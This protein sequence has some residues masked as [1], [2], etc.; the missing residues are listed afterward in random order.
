MTNAFQADDKYWSNAKNKWPASVWMRFDRPHLLEKIGFRNKEIY[1]TP[2]TV[3]VI[4]SNDCKSWKTLLSVEDSG[5]TKGNE[6]RSWTIPA[7]NR[8]K[9]SCFGLMWPIKQVSQCVSV[10][11]ILMW[12]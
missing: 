1:N 4:G 8:S 11:Q 6:F 2:K 3:E 10:R 7:E 12:E 5:F 9:F